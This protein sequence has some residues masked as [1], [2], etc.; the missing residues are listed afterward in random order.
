M[1]CLLL[2]FLV[3]NDDDLLDFFSFNSK[4]TIKET[5]ENGYFNCQ[6]KGCME[7][8]SCSATKCCKLLYCKAH[9][10]LHDS[11]TFCTLEGIDVSSRLDRLAE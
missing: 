3:E 7:D 4:V 8:W 2:T 6:I 11:Q 9:K 10:E 5:G 1:F